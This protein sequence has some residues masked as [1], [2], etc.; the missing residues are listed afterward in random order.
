MTIPEA[1]QKELIYVVDD[2]GTVVYLQAPALKDAISLVH[3]ENLDRQG[4]N[5]QYRKSEIERMKSSVQK[6]NGSEH[7]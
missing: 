1:F 4:P 3:L 5:D 2:V 6:M 7:L